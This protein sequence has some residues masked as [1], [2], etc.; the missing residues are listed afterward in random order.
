M[1]E[2]RDAILVSYS[3][4]CWCLSLSFFFFPFLLSLILDDRWNGTIFVGCFNPYHLYCLISCECM[5]ARGR[6]TSLYNNL[7]IFTT[8]MWNPNS[9]LLN[10]GDIDDENRF[11][12]RTQKVGIIYN[13]VRVVKRRQQ[14][15]FESYLAVQCLPASREHSGK[16]NRARDMWIQMY[17]DC[18]YHQQAME[19]YKSGMI[20]IFW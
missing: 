12:Q 19:V 1:I 9:Y 18:R 13:L 4:W 5:K 10:A 6:I 11:M 2:Q 17:T 8:S 15:S 14:P 7:L 16:E 20:L 3:N